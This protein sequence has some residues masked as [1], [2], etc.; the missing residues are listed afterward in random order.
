MPRAGAAG[1]SSAN[2]S[3]QGQLVA[4]PTLQQRHGRLLA[5]SGLDL[6]GP[7]R[8][9]GWPGSAFCLARTWGA[10]L[11]GTLPAGQG[12][13]SL[14][15][16]QNGDGG[17]GYGGFLPPARHPRASPL[18]L[19]AVWT[20][21]AHGSGC[22]WA[23]GCCSGGTLLR[24]TAPRWPRALG[25]GPAKLAVPRRS[26]TSGDSV[27]CARRMPV[28]AAQ[29]CPFPIVCGPVANCLQVTETVRETQEPWL[30]QAVSAPRRGGGG[31]SRV[32]AGQVAHPCA[33]LL[34]EKEPGCLWW[35]GP[36]RVQNPFGPSGLA[37]LVWTQNVPKREQGQGSR[38][39][40][41][42]LTL[43]RVDESKRGSSPHPEVRK[44]L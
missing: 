42:P 17:G 16:H 15:G 18:P 30:P 40:G 20:P 9:R 32:T 7:A 22:P 6:D 35:P 21:L 14:R 10:A 38:V 12:R 24:S 39:P 33:R 36:Y 19:A 29:G 4:R 28:V 27:P 13:L 1:S 44:S 3:L 11:W 2:S 34:G 23:D 26:P 41:V 43:H 8:D 31:R 5:C 25:A 37:L